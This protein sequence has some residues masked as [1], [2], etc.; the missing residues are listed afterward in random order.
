M[1]NKVRY[2]RMITRKSLIWKNATPEYLNGSQRENRWLQTG[3]ETDKTMR[4]QSKPSFIIRCKEQAVVV[5]EPRGLVPMHAN[6]LNEHD[7][8]LRWM[9]NDPLKVIMKAADLMN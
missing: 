6:V 3:W 5:T 7:P 1:T 9:D 2:T 8:R 4:A